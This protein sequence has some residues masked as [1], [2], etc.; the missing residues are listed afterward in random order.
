MAGTVT[1]HCKAPDGL[2]IAL[3]GRDLVRVHGPAG[4]ARQSLGLPVAGGYALTRHVDADLFA[5]WVAANKDHPAVAGR[6][7][8]AMPEFAGAAES[9]QPA[10]SEPA[11][12]DACEGRAEASEASAEAQ[13]PAEEPGATELGGAFRSEPPI[14]A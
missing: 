8:F 6:M 14:H 10:A 4:A 3:N 13:E 11:E 2:I 7:I 12:V 1:V 9:A 5:A